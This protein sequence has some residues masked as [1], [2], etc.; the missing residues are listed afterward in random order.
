MQVGGY[1]GNGLNPFINKFGAATHA[2][3]GLFGH[4][5][6]PQLR[7][8]AEKTAG[9]SDTFAQ[10][11]VSRI[12]NYQPKNLQGVEAY[13][14]QQTASVDTQAQQAQESTAQAKDPSGLEESLSRAVDFVRSQFGDAAA[15]ATMGLVYKSIGN[16]EVTEENLG[17]GLLQAVRFIDRNFGF[18][19][20]DKLMAHFNQDVNK[21]MNDFFDNGLMETFY[22]V[23][24]NAKQGGGK[25]QGL[26]LTS[27]MQEVA[28]QYGQ[29]AVSSI[30]EALEEALQSGEKPGAA[31]RQAVQVAGEDMAAQYGGEAKDHA[32]LIG[33]SLAPLFH[34]QGQ[35]GNGMVPPPQAGGQLD[36]RV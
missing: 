27:A 7:A 4:P 17:K 22:A 16:G 25:A 35:A 11:I 30:M 10:D 14:Q 9:L 24:P 13:R 20:G 8:S 34:G 36:I 5:G 26:Q 6:S 33:Q 23:S 31:L 19:A 2:S 21:A 12:G 32:A 18:A 15:Q 1:M 28:K 29:D 3:K